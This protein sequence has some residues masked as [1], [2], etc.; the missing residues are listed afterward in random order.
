[1]WVRFGE[2]SAVQQI[3]RDDVGCHESIT[4]KDVSLDV[5]VSS[6]WN[7]AYADVGGGD[8][9]QKVRSS[10]NVHVGREGV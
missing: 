6:S 4:H 3:S 9:G 10:S 2:I 1:M 7:R 8:E 5:E